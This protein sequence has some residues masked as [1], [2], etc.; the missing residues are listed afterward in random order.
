[1]RVMSSRR[2]LIDI[3][4]AMTLQTLPVDPRK[5]PRDPFDRRQW[6]FAELKR[7]G[8]SCRKLSIDADYN[9]SYAAQC[10]YKP[11]QP[12]EHLIAAA[13]GITAA[14]LFPERHDEHGQRLSRCNPRRKS[15][16]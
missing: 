9:P 13:L 12:A 1:M 10:L 16:H 5:I 15:N 8:T 6:V 2:H 11:L 7:R 14:A 4:T 3:G